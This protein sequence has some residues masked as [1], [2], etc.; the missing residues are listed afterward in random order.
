MMDMTE[1]RDALAYF[2][3][4]VRNAGFAPTMEGNLLTEEE[5]GQ[6]AAGG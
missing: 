5:H 2:S 1:R 4:V 3:G 6:D